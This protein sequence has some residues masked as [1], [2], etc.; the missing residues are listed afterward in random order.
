MNIQ[1]V[2]FKILPELH[3]LGLKLRE[4]AYEFFDTSADLT[5]EID[6]VIE[7][8]KG[9]WLLDNIYDII[10]SESNMEYTIGYNEIRSDD[11]Y[12]TLYIQITNVENEAVTEMLGGIGPNTAGISGPITAISNPVFK[13]KTKKSTEAVEIITNGQ[14]NKVE[15]LYRAYVNLGT[16]LQKYLGN[17]VANVQ[18]PPRP[19]VSTPDSGEFES[20]IPADDLVPMDIFKMCSID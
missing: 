3:T 20:N 1:D 9:E 11:G 13:D 4:I 8:E 19:Y 12:S 15:D 10:V 18:H 7:E 6:G 16:E 5:I 17:P 2:V 14:F